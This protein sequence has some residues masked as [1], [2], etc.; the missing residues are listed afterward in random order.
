MDRNYDHAFGNVPLDEAALLELLI[1]PPPPPRPALSKPIASIDVVQEDGMPKSPSMARGRPRTPK[2]TTNLEDPFSQTLFRGP[3]SPMPTTAFIP[4]S[5]PE[6]VLSPDG[7]FK[8]SL[9]LGSSLLNVFFADGLSQELLPQTPGPQDGRTIMQGSLLPYDPFSDSTSPAVASPLGSH[10]AAML[11]SSFS[12]TADFSLSLLTRLQS[13]GKTSKAAAA[14]AACGPSMFPSECRATPLTSYGPSESSLFGF[15]FVAEHSILEGEAALKF[16]ERLVVVLFGNASQVPPSDNMAAA[17]ALTLEP[18]TI[19]SNVKPSTELL[20]KDPFEPKA[21]EM[22]SV[23]ASPCAVTQGAVDPCIISRPG[24]SSVES[25]TKPKISKPFDESPLLPD[26]VL[27]NTPIFN[28]QVLNQ[29]FEAEAD[30]LETPLLTSD[31]SSRTAVA[32]YNNSTMSPSLAL[33]SSPPPPPCSYAH[34]DAA[35]V[36]FYSGKGKRLSDGLTAGSL[37][38]AQHLL[39]DTATGTAMASHAAAKP[40][41]TG[42]LR[43]RIGIKRR[44]L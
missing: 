7:D 32:A 8:A 1:T 3:D 26:P 34:E 35:Y 16:R 22:R 24:C 15:V 36:G 43:K 12:L 4:D 20:E 28:T 11:H 25:P 5:Q 38:K 30:A 14:A 33:P 9:A 21:L 41:P 10:D 39:D 2:P 37:S 44:R 17:E 13:D 27:D 19:P 18:R 6:D 40:P 31:S 29:F 42:T 23:A